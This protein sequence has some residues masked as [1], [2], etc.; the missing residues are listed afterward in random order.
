MISVLKKYLEQNR[1]SNLNE[2]F[3]D[4]YLSH[5]NYPSLFSVTD[6]LEVLRIEN[7]A[8]NVPKN[9]LENLPEH[10]IAAIEVKDALN[11][12]FVSKNHDTIIYET[13]NNEKHTVTLEEF[14][15]L[16]K[17]LILAIEKNEKPSDIK[18]SE[19][20]IAITLALLAT[21]YLVSNFAYGFE[22]YGFLFRTL[23]FIGL[24]AGIFILLEKN[25]NGNELVSKICS[26]NSN[27]SCDSVIKSKNSRITQWLDFTDLPI[28]FFSI[29]FIAGSLA[30]FAFGIIGLLSLLSLPVC[31]YS[32]YLQQTKLK[33]WCMLCLVV[34]SLVLAQSLLYILYFD[35]F[36]INL[37]A[38]IHYTIITVICSALWFPLKKII[39]E[40]KD[41]ADKNKELSRFKRNF[42]LFEFL[43]SD[44]QELPELTSL[45]PI[46]FGNPEASLTLRLF[47]SP[48]CGHCHTAY[49]KGKDFMEKYPE[50]IR[51]AV[52]FNLNID[53]LG[54]PYVPVATNLQQIYFSNGNIRQAIEDWHVQNLNIEDW[55]K[56]WKQQTISEEV[57]TELNRQ[58]QWCIKNE[59]NYTP[60]K[61]V[62]H[63]LLPKEY[64][65]EE[66]KYFLSELEDLKAAIV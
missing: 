10:F 5:P 62:D 63:K 2:E 1:H 43:S 11:F 24:L 25:E 20:K 51:L 50:K 57:A 41:L 17:G 15:E 28:L 48:S 36:K 61:I 53:N 9:Q 26:F 32:V 30:G 16:W 52:Y 40:R 35:N 38:A 3:K 44:V 45:K 31:L 33:K 34:S 4:I 39:S 55:L 29:N 13:E 65:L 23:S 56:K 6:T 66:I 64:E 7:M 8:A 21:V 18:K 22:I 19:H 46:L 12:V 14:R 47:L 60:V 27:T 58:Y 37:T 54:N 49:Q 59:F 42:K